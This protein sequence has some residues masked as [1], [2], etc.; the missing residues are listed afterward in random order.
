MII[1][2][3][4]IVYSIKRDWGI[5]SGTIRK[6][7]QKTEKKKKMRQNEKDVEERRVVGVERREGEKRVEQWDKKA[8]VCKGLIVKQRIM[9]HST[10]R[11]LPM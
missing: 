10:Q 3:N 6:L 8:V 9:R 2:Y 7:F 5:V 4:A 1:E 11:I